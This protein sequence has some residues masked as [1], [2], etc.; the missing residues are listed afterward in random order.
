V[1]EITVNLAPESLI[2]IKKIENMVVRGVMLT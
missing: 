2:F 1:L